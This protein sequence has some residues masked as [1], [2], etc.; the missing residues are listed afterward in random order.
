M[1][2][3]Q[4]VYVVDDNADIRDSL[5]LLLKSVGL[6]HQV[7]GSAAE[8]ID[9]CSPAARGCLLLDI[10]MPDIS[11]IQLQQRMKDAGF[12]LPVIFITGHGDVPLAVE[13]MKNGAM[14]FLQKP[15]SDLVLLDIIFRALE[16]DRQQQDELEQKREIEARLETLSKRELQVMERMAIGDMTKVIASDLGISPRTVEVHRA[17]IMD[18][19]RCR[20]LAQLIL[21]LTQVRNDSFG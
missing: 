3:E 14:D 5:S 1:S 2:S 20:T 11:G 6:D 8:F 7:Y 17:R 13:A 9:K 12:G 10:R 16:L 19:M 4:T 18:K 21:M 15:F